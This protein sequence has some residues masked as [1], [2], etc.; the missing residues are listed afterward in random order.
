MQRKLNSIYESF[1]P[2]SDEP[3]LLQQL[4]REAVQETLAGLGFDTSSPAKI[5]ADMHY[6]RRMRQGAEDMASL[7]R[8]SLLTIFI[9]T[10]LYM[11][12]QAAK[13]LVLKGNTH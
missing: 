3:I 9:S 2:P 4:I 5:Q 12:W 1:M 13:D 6:L 10:A 11:L 7:T 8:T